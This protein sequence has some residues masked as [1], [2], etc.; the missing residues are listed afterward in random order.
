MKIL[1]TCVGRRK[2]LVDY[3][4][5]EPLVSLVVGA[6]MQ[7]NAPGFAGCDVC[8]IVPSIY[9]ENYI[10]TIKS[11]CENHKIDL[12][13]SLN[14]M[15]LPILSRDRKSIE[16][17]G[18]KLAISSDSVINICSDKWVSYKFALDCGIDT[19]KTYISTESALFDVSK[20]EVSFP[21]IVKPRWGSASFG[22][23]IANN[24]DE[25]TR[26]FNQCKINLAESYLS[27]F[28]ESLDS[29]I[30]QEFIDGFEY[31]VDI[32]NSFEGKFISS[33]QKLKIAMRSGETD[34]ATTVKNERLAGITKVL[35]DNLKHIGN[36]DCDF[37]EANGRFYLL[38][39]N[40]RFGG[41]YPF[42]HEAGSNYVKNLIESAQGIELT[43]L[44]YRESLT[45]SK[46]DTLV[47]SIGNQ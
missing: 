11:I 31:G 39:M 7:V 29:V 37:F 34:K 28:A 42:S 14:D 35:S 25:L 22:L 20:K 26:Y 46:C 8:E 2:Y 23:F 5:N 4:K 12:L 47:P 18:T 6:D 15:E 40:P 17:V 44:S 45:F 43:P 32:F 30:I 38:E 19:P 9:D 16:S 24:E 13:V 41:G 36:L 1:L 21:L 3:F 33:T 27:S 10:Q